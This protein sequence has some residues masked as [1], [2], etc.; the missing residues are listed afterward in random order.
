[1]AVLSYLP[2]LMSPIYHPMT[3][4]DPLVMVASPPSWSH[5][6][7]T[8]YMGRDILS[9]LLVGGGWPS[10][11]ASSRLHQRGPGGHGGHGQ[12][13]AGGVTDSV[14]MRLAD[15]IM[16]MPTLL[17]ILMLSSLFGTLSIWTVVL[18]IAL[19]SGRGSR[20]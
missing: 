18:M 4:V 5:W 14:L 6:L 15:I 1:M 16:V 10:W 9:Q 12:R 3:G 11:W 13:Y 8:D 19:F 17:V 2:P 20:G 7:G